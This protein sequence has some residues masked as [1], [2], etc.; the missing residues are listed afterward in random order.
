MP[1]CILCR[2]RAGKTPSETDIVAHVRVATWLDDLGVPIAP[3]EAHG[4]LCGLLAT[5]PG[6]LAKS[7]WFGELLD[8]AGLQAVEVAGRADQLRAVD[9]WFASTA[10][11][12][13]DPDFGFHPLLPDD[14]TP[15]AAR[16]RALGDFCAGFAYGVGIGIGHATVLS[17][18]AR[19][20]LDDLQAIDR[21]AD[22]AS[23]DV[24]GSDSRDDEA[25]LVEL[26]EYVRVGV[27]LIHEER[28]PVI[29][30]EVAHRGAD[31][32]QRVH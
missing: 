15:I 26:I 22:S 32:A 27:L 25:S 21:Q 17:P 11:A 2:M 12:L 29:E 30:P 20:V 4:L 31:G 10:E 8:A 28:R 1:H 5:Q 13:N 18:D 16:V 6:H 24:Q 23:D 19:E 9:A 7:R 14:D 3:S